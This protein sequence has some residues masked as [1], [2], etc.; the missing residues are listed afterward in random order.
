MKSE[1]IF[2][3]TYDAH[4]G[5]LSRVRKQTHHEVKKTLA[6][7]TLFLSYCVIRE[8]KRAVKKS[9]RI[10]RPIISSGYGEMGQVGTIGQPLTLMHNYHRRQEPSPGRGCRLSVRAYKEA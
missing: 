1:E 7:I 10:E 8:E 3:C 4:V 2:H 9:R 6:N 5:I